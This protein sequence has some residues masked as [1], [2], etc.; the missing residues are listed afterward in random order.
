MNHDLDTDTEDIKHMCDTCRHRIYCHGAYKKII[1]VVIM[2]N[3]RILMRTYKK[4]S[5]FVFRLHW[6]HLGYTALC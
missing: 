6:L 2:R 3:K 5:F 1:G 4:S